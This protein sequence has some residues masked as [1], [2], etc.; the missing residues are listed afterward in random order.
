MN[1]ST[2]EKLILAKLHLPVDCCQMIKRCLPL[3][4]PTPTAQLMKEVCVKYNQE[5]GH[6][7]G[8]TR[9]SGATFVNG[10]GLRIYQLIGRWSHPPLRPEIQYSH[11]YRDVEYWRAQL[12]DHSTGELRGRRGIRRVRVMWPKLEPES[13]PT[14]EYYTRESAD[15]MAHRVRSWIPVS[16]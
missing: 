1:R 2:L 10:S 9:F 12:W 3:N 5:D 14:W 15:E 7:I 8:Y 16:V 11:T 13:L 4:P 6:I